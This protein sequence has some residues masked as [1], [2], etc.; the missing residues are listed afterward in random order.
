MV[1]EFLMHITFG[2]RMFVWSLSAMTPLVLVGLF[3]IIAGTIP[4]F[5]EFIHRKFFF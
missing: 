4:P 3:L 2:T 1:I 5:H